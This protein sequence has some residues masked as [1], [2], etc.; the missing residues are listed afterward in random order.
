MQQTWS[1][2]LMGWCRKWEQRLLNYL[3][4]K[5]KGSYS[6]VLCLQLPTHIWLEYTLTHLLALWLRLEKME[7]YT[8]HCIRCQWSLLR[9]NVFNIRSAVLTSKA[10]TGRENYFCLLNIE[11]K[12]D[13]ILSVKA[14]KLYLTLENKVREMWLH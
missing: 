4:P 8:D 3:R 13:T 10:V 1:G 7:E 5:Q 6:T 14:K 9:T 2:P 12:K 11:R